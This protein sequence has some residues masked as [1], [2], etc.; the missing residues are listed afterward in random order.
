LEWLAPKRVK[1]IQKFL[2]LA[3]YYCQ[4]IKDFSRISKLLHELVRKKQKWEWGNR[5]KKAF[6]KLKRRY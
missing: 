5:Q 6:E 2:G 1:N 4:F 3:N